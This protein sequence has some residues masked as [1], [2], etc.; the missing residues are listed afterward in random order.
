[1][2][3]DTHPSSVVSAY[4]PNMGKLM[5]ATPA[6]V[7]PLC[8]KS[9]QYFSLLLHECL[10][11]RDESAFVLRLS[12][13]EDCFVANVPQDGNLY[14]AQTNGP[15]AAVETRCEQKKKRRDRRGIKSKNL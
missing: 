3:K 14:L 5:V 7:V 9:T 2:E 6:R 10:K 12:S 11:A 13:L 1:M 8:E 15:A 4:V